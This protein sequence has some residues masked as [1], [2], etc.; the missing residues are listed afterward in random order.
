MKIRSDYVSNSSSSSFIIIGDKMDVK[1]FDIEAFN[2][3]GD[4]EVYLLVLPNRGSEG[5]Y[6]FA[7]TPEMLM[8]FDMHQLDL[9]N[10]NLPLVKAKYYITEG[11]YLHKA[12]KFKKMSTS[13]W[14]DDDD[15]EDDDRLDKK[16]RGDGMEFPAGCKMFRFS[17][18]YGNPRERSEI[19]E[20]IETALKYG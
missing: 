12:S 6:I 16:C 20:E 7:L 15:D 2:S 19:L 18:D 8:D 9:S 11:G 17:K 13:D 5:D 10:G 4:D 1:K 14:Y 3:I